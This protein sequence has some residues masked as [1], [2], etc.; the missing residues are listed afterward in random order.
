MTDTRIDQPATQTADAPTTFVMDEPPNRALVGLFDPN[1]DLIPYVFER[2]NTHFTEQGQQWYGVSDEECY[3]WADI[4]SLAAAKGL[5]VVRLYRADDPA[6][7]D[8]AHWRDRAEKAERLAEQRID[9]ALKVIGG[10]DPGL[11]AT[12]AQVA[13]DAERLRADLDAGILADD[14]G[15]TTAVNL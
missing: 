10:G 5:Q 2:D 8:C 1:N 15:T 11:G 13:Y 14:L 4:L 12:L 9:A 7:A 3:R 6:V